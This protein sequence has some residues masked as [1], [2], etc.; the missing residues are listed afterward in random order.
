MDPL[1]EIKRLYFATTRA[2]IDRDVRRAIDCLKQMKTPDERDRAA[3]Y[4]S[5][6]AEMRREW[7]KGAGPTKRPRR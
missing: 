4:M 2:T 7:A 6:L 1:D 5:G 3:V